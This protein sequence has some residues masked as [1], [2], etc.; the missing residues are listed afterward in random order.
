MD[1]ITPLRE[2]NET[3][4][5]AA[6]HLFT[7]QAARRGLDRN[8]TFDYTLKA[9]VKNISIEILDAKGA[10]IRTFTN[11]E[12]EAAKAAAAPPPRSARTSRAD[13]RSPSRRW[14]PAITA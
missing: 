1:N 14:W 5:T 3:T 10:A 7:P 9:P 6:V 11:S 8:L 12:A 2:R 4:T 13:R